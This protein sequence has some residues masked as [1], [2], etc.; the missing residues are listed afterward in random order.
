M[1]KELHNWY[2][3]CLIKTK[4]KL[5]FS[6]ISPDHSN[7]HIA[8]KHSSLHCVVFAERIFFKFYKFQIKVALRKFTLHNLPLNRTCL[9]NGEKRKRYNYYKCLSLILEIDICVC[10]YTYVHVHTHTHMLTHSYLTCFL[11]TF[12]RTYP[13]LSGHIYSIKFNR[14]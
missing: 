8:D 11:A 6:A 14:T 13:E 10:L 1:H 7:L 3:S 12:K 9:M 5:F 4:I 2:K